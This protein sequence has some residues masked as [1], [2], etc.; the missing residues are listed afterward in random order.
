M[1]ARGKRERSGARR[2][3]YIIKC[4]VA[5]KGRNTGDIS[6]IQALTSLYRNP[7]ATRF[8]SLAL[9][10]G[11]HIA[12]LRRSLSTFGA[13][14]RVTVVCVVKLMTSMDGGE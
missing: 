9:A 13:T 5:L 12:R 8:A 14:P 3:W 4:R 6:A 10:P 7:G 2:P 1:K 11:F